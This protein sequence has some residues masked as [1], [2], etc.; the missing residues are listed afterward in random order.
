[1]SG[2]AR[3][4]ALAAALGAALAGCATAGQPARTDESE[5]LAAPYRARAADLERKG[6]LRAALDARKVV[7]TLTP[8]NADAQARRGRLEARIAREVSDRMRRGGEALARREEFAAR[9]HF[10]VVLALDPANQAAL[11]ALRNQV[12][13]VRFVVHTVLQGDTLASVAQRY[14]SDHTRAE[15]IREANQLPPNS[16]LVAGTA[17]RIPE[18][19]EAPLK[20]EA[21]M[22]TGTSG[23]SREE[24][25]PDVNPLLTDARDSLERQEYADAL[26]DVDKLLAGNPRDPEGVKL[27]KQILYAL[28]KA[29]LEQSNYEES[30]R[31]LSQLARLAPSYEDAPT[32]LSQARSRLVQQH[33]TQALQ[34]YQEERLEEAIAEWRSV[35]EL[36]P[37]HPS[38]RKNIDQAERILKVL[39]GQTK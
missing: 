38:A 36:D 19:P 37:A 24:I 35:L 23:P 29:E 39:E 14:Y 8:D 21:S 25:R 16:R 17:L 2:R 18:I 27:K 13:D 34:Y 15:L 22:S 12:K 5:A 30:Y 9:H 1:V 20:P 3:R 7:L 10:L 28:G 33:H 4:L 26:A 31:A 6:S 32:L 11:D